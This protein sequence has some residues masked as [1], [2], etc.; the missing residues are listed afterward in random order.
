MKARKKEEVA[1]AISN[2]LYL[3]FFPVALV[4]NGDAEIELEIIEKI[5]SPV[6]QDVCL[7]G[8]IS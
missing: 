4:N 5:T 8:T 6:F 7:S 2:Q 1:I 3:L